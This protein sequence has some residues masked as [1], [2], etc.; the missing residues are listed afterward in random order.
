MGLGLYGPFDS[1]QVATC[2]K[3]TAVAHWREIGPVQQQLVNC[4][5]HDRLCTARTHETALSFQLEL[6]QIRFRDDFFKNYV[7]ELFLGS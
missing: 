1:V 2:S 6:W 4:M 5:L 3:Y 7:N